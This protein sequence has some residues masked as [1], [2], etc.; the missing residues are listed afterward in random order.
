[1]DPSREGRLALSATQR[2][3]D[4]R[5]NKPKSLV[6]HGGSMFVYCYLHLDLPYKTAEQRLIG[7]L[8][9]LDGMASSA[10]RDGESLRDRIGIGGSKAPIVAKS[11]RIDVG[12]PRRGEMETD[13]PISWEATGT[14]GLFPTMEGE[15]LI[16]SLGEDLTQLTFRGS[17]TPPLG[18]LGR[19][20]DRTMMHHVAEVSVKR[21]V[22]HIAASIE[23]NPELE[24]ANGR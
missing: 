4:T 15:I 2:L 9:G 18:Q 17:Y 10:Y 24:V 16:S 19:A 20:I 3:Y 8:A 12:A 21:F 5:E 1:M 7:L 22:D 11:I 13:I 14:P 6:T 23:D